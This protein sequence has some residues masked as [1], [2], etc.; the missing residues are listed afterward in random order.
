MCYLLTHPQIQ[1][2]KRTTIHFCLPVYRVDKQLCWSGPSLVDFS[3]SS[4][5]SLKHLQSSSRFV[6]GWKAVGLRDRVTE[7]HVCLSI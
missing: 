7:S 2:L 3:V 6:S 5:H 1:W 4:H